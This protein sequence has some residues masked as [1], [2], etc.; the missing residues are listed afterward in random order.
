VKVIPVAHDGT[1]RALP[2]DALSEVPGWVV[3]AVA[4]GPAILEMVETLQPSQI[5]LD[6][7]MTGPNEIAVYRLLRERGCGVSVLQ[8]TAEDRRAGYLA[9]LAPAAGTRMRGR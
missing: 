8:V 5:A 6:R 1:V 7:H 3:P 9:L 4:N 2:K